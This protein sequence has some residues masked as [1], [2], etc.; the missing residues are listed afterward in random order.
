[1]L[2]GVR[3]A[4]TAARDD[5]GEIVAA[6]EELL[7]ALTEANGLIP[8]DIVSGFFTVTPDLT[9]EF[10]ARAARRL[11]WND[12]ALLGAVEVAVAAAPVRCIRVLLH[13]YTTRPPA[14][15]RHVYLRGASELRPDRQ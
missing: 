2:R 8:D 14:A 11:G 3:G 9:T 10:P 13:V 15:I 12:V 1:M 4:T 7:R 6:T 5:P